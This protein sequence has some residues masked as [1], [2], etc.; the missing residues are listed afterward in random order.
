[1]EALKADGEK[2]HIGGEGAGVP[3][4]WLSW[5]SDHFWES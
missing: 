2:K 3:G 5:S 1:M 4:Q